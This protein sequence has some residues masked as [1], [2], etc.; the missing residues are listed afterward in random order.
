MSNPGRE[1]GANENGEKVL[2]G[3]AGTGVGG[4]RGA[5]AGGQTI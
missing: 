2:P 1:T 3:E 5:M 4:N